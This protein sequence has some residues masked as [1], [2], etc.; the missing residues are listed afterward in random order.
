MIKKF[1]CAFSYIIFAALAIGQLGAVAMEK[2][3]DVQL[4]E[5]PVTVNY[6]ALD[7]EMLA[8]PVIMYNNV[9]YLPLDSFMISAVGLDVTVEKEYKLK[10]FINKNGPELKYFI[11]KKENPLEKT[12]YVDFAYRRSVGSPTMVIGLGHKVPNPRYIPP[13]NLPDRSSQIAEVLTVKTYFNGNELDNENREYPFLVYSG[14]VYM[15]LDW[16]TVNEL[17]WKFVYDKENGITITANSRFFE[18]GTQSEYIV[19]SNTC[20]KIKTQSLYSIP[21]V[22]AP[23]DE[24]YI[25][26]NGG[27]FIKAYGGKLR[28]RFGHIYGYDL[29]IIS[30]NIPSEFTAYGN[31]RYYP[32][33]KIV[34]GY[35][36]INA[37]TNMIADNFVNCRLKIDLET[38]E[39]EVL[40]SEPVDGDINNGIIWTKI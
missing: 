32:Q 40:E 39:I 6:Q 21:P 37:F 11:Y 18:R 31:N 12:E 20:I 24:L 4:C 36:Y 2:S 26:K 30:G 38:F 19:S 5:I 23:V 28:W 3:V 27:E 16:N 35:L 17:G 1:F 25:A 8:Y 10:Y 22:Q 14:L 33:A 9:T 15:P 29:E 13:E 34:D 7:N